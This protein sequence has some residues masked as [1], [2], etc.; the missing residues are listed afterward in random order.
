MRIEQFGR[1]VFLKVGAA[2]EHL[3]T[4]PT[5]HP[6]VRDL[7]LI[8][9]DFEQG[10]ALGTAGNHA[11]SVVQQRDAPS[12]NSAVIN[13]QPSSLSATDSKQYGA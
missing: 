6:A 8:S 1:R 10:R 11:Q 7:Q 13:T 9:D 12:R 4:L 3:A 2:V 5:S